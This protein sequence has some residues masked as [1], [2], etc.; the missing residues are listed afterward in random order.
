MRL[1]M[2]W[3]LFIDDE[4]MPN[5]FR[6]LPKTTPVFIARTYASAK[7]I[8]NNSF[9]EF[10]P[11]SWISFDHDLGDEEGDGKDLANFTVDLIMKHSLVWVDNPQM[12]HMGL[13]VRPGHNASMPQVW[14]HSMNVVGKANID[15]LFRNF[16][17][18]MLSE[19]QT[20]YWP[21]GK[22]ISR[23]ACGWS[24]IQPKR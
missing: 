7:K 24:P 1:D 6:E 19:E 14:S 9:K 15:G 2:D 21:K 13:R 8:L 18:R 11:P 10:N 3:A 16:E 12:N 4:R 22:L 23:D 20:L 5:D 17:E